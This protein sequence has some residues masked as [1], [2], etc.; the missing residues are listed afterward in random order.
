MKWYH[1]G[2]IYVRILRDLYV[3]IMTFRIDPA[4]LYRSFI[5]K[6]FQWEVHLG[7]NFVGFS[8]T[9]M[10]ARWLFSLKV[11]YTMGL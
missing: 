4:M 10:N 11:N 5:L 2:Y 3:A 9:V 6:T 1:C 8:E 7:D